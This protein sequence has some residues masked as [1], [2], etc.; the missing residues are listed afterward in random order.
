VV[1]RSVHRTLKQS[2]QLVDE[3]GPKCFV[4]N[5]GHVTALSPAEEA[6]WRA[7]VIERGRKAG[8][9]LR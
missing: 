5:F 3:A 8:L 9:V 4:D 1:V 7:M 6:K 2:L